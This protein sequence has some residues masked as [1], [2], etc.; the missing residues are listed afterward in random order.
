MSVTFVTCEACQGEGRIITQGQHVWDE[1]D[2][3]ICPACHGDCVVEVDTNPAGE[4]DVYR[5]NDSLPE[6]KR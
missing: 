4:A 2:H 3:G 5:W 1:I 6:S